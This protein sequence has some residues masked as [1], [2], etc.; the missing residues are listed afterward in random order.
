MTTQFLV[1]VQHAC[2]VEKNEWL[3]VARLLD[4]PAHTYYTSE[5]AARNALKRYLAR[6]NRKH[7]YREDGTRAEHD[8]CGYI[9]IDTVYTKADDDQMRVVAWKI[10]TRV[11]SAWELLEEN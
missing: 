5:E 1:M 11:V 7:N 2:G 6:W 10:K 9:G 8:R 3:N 4:G